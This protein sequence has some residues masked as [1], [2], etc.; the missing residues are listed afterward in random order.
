MPGAENLRCTKPSRG[1]YR[2]C[3][4]NIFQGGIGVRVLLTEVACAPSDVGVTSRRD[5]REIAPGPT[6]WRQP[7]RVASRQTLY[8]ASEPHDVYAPTLLGRRGGLHP[9]PSGGGS[10]MVD[11]ANHVDEH[12]L[13]ATASRGDSLGDGGRRVGTARARR[14]R[15]RV[16]PGRAGGQRFS[17]TGPRTVRRSR[18]L[19]RV[20]PAIAPLV[21]GG[22]QCAA[23]VC[24]RSRS[25]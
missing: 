4:G 9:A 18:A 17:W 12:G 7:P 6:A 13:G 15:L 1:R 25:R 20:C 16:L 21:S 23:S 2:V 10:D 8:R 14:E 3:G 11:A 19:A 24:V 22:R 5:F